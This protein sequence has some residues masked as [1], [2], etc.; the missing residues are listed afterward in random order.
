MINYITALP[1]FIEMQRV[2]FCWFIAQGLT[3]ELNAFSRMYDFTQTTE[4]I[5]FG[6]EYRLVKPVYNIIRAKKYTANYSAQLIIPIEVRNKE[7]NSIKH[8]SSFSIIN[9]PLM[10][11]F[12]TFIINGCER[13]V[14][15]QIIRSPGV[16]FEKNK[17]QKN[18]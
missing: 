8:N 15:S 14:V 3:E 4:Y 1:D 16:Y 13:V 12:A 2:S 10:T 9:L 5:L 6:Q 18:N 11:S 7:I 17:H